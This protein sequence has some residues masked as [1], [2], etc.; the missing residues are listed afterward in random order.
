MNR[1]TLFIFLVLVC[2][3]WIGVRFSVAECVYGDPNDHDPN[4]H[5]ISGQVLWDGS[6]CNGDM[7]YRIVGPVMV[8]T[9]ATLTI[10]GGAN[11]V[12]D[13]SAAQLQVQGTL[14]ATG[15][16]QSPV[17]F[18][19]MQDGITAI[20]NTGTVTLSGCIFESLYTGML[21][22]GIAT[23]T[24]CLFDQLEY[25]GLSTGVG[26]GGRTVRVLSS[27]FAAS[28]QT[29]GIRVQVN[30][31]GADLVSI[32]NC[33]FSSPAGQGQTGRG[34]R[35]T[36]AIRIQSTLEIGN[37][38][39]ENLREGIAGEITGYYLPSQATHIHNNYFWSNR[40][41][42]RC[43]D[44]CTHRFSRNAFLDNDHNFYMW[45]VEQEYD[46]NTDF[47][48]NLHP[49]N[50]AIDPTTRRLRYFPQHVADAAN[51]GINDG[52]AWFGLDADGSLPDVSL[53]GGDN[54]AEED[55]YV[56]LHDPD[57]SAPYSVVSNI[58][59]RAT[60]R[61]Q[62]LFDVPL[63]ATVSIS[64]GAELRFDAGAGIESF[65]ASSVTVGDPEGADPR[66]VQFRRNGVA[67]WRGLDIGR[68]TWAFHNASIAGAAVGIVT[69]V[70]LA[71]HDASI[72][73]CGTGVLLHSPGTTFDDVEISDC[74]TGIAYSEVS[75]PQNVL[76]GSLS[77]SNC[78]QTGLLLFGSQLTMQAPEGDELAVTNNY[79]GIG[80]DFQ[81]QLH[82]QNARLQDNGSGLHVFVSS[83]ADLTGC[84]ILGNGHSPSM[85]AGGIRL[86]AGGNLRMRCTSVQANVGP[87]IW[88]NDG[89]LIMQD[90]RQGWGTVDWGGNDIS[91]N[92][93]G[94]G[95]IYIQRGILDMADGKTRVMDLQM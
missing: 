37:C 55:A 47:P 80:V 29:Y 63:D 84:E 10:T 68:G 15:S 81:S 5:T 60:Y 75:D 41:G 83:S 77:I 2:T 7:T 85:T 46:E 18:A 8:L 93:W 51:D 28:A 72:S 53:F 86:M 21:D 30:G 70:G 56:L 62:S 66:T 88:V 42:V 94:K 32:R 76:T 69:S 26:G 36:S 17:V 95:Q 91:F 9:G 44:Y 71:L 54:V 39:F 1:R 65:E 33:L 49:V 20:F 58:L 90:E 45:F 31:G 16:P 23:V 61:V 64:P 89:T 57:E 74:K 3:F 34:I 40:F 43:T 6:D 50:N 14:L 48:N 24:G 19:G 25:T 35:I 38:Q 59:E 11:I 27:T 52:D 4:H 82:L 73:S 79:Q 87:G 92:S 67:E 22:L 78:S 12:F 13:T